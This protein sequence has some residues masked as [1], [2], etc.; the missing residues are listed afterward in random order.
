MRPTPADLARDLYLYRTAL[1][2]ARL[3]GKLRGA[4]VRDEAGVSLAAVVRRPHRGRW[5][6][7]VLGAA[8]F[9]VA[10]LLMMSVVGEWAGGAWILGL[11]VPVLLLLA[12]GAVVLLTPEPR[13]ALLSDAGETVL[14][15]EP[16]SRWG[17]WRVNGI[18]DGEGLR[19][20]GLR[21]APL[22]DRFWPLGHVAPLIVIEPAEGARISV[23]RASAWAPGWV[24]TCEGQT[25]AH[26]AIR[27]PPGSRDRLEVLDRAVDPRLLLAAILVARP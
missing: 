9:T 27:T 8:A 3:R 5:F 13:F 17:W 7:R 1:P 6:A 4:H 2:G 18:E 22:R 15:V 20:G 24:F 14:R 16:G 19:L 23:Q 10:T 25:V 21:R 12:L 26:Y 11:S